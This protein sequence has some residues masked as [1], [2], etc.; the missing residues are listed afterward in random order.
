VVGRKGRF[1]TKERSMKADT[2]NAMSLAELHSSRLSNCNAS[3]SSSQSNVLSHQGLLMVQS[4]DTKSL[5]KPKHSVVDRLTINN[6]YRS[7]IDLILGTATPRWAKLQKIVSLFA[8]VA[9]GCSEA[10]E[11]ATTLINEIENG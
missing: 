1:Y 6:R 4:I 2:E 10:L 7:L 9:L 8:Q 5:L 11:A 3:F